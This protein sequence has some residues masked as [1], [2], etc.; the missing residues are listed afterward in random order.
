MVIKSTSIQ[1]IFFFSDRLAVAVCC[2][3]VGTV[4]ISSSADLKKALSP[5]GVEF[6]F[7]CKSRGVVNVFWFC[8]APRCEVSAESK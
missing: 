7:V 4:T 8:V 5:W 3:R 6:C 1:D 2:G